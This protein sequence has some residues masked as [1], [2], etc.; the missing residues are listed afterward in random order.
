MPINFSSFVK[1]P[2]WQEI[3]SYFQDE[4]FDK[5]LEV[6]TKGMTSEVI[7]LEYKARE[8]AAKII[9]KT[10]NKFERKAGTPIKKATPF[11]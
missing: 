8:L 2:E 5:P 7:A 1:S 11:I 4:V 9:K 3:K 6:E 10:L